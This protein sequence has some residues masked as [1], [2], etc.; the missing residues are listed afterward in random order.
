M[1]QH[2][3]SFARLYE[4]LLLAGVELTPQD[5]QLFLTLARTRIETKKTY[6]EHRSDKEWD[7][8]RLR[9][10]R[11]G[12]G[13]GSREPTNPLASQVFS[14]PQL[15]ETRHLVGR[16]DWLASIMAS[17]QDALPKKLLVMQGPIG[18][19]KSSELHRIALQVISAEP[20]RHHVMLCELPAGEQGGD[21]QRTLDLLLGALLAE[22]APSDSA[23]PLTSLDVR[24]TFVLRCLEKS[25]R[26]FLLLVDNAERVLDERATR[27]RREQFL[28]S[29]AQPASHHAG[30]GNEGM[31]RLVRG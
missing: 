12:P 3:I 21:P 7:E 24:I 15:V 29:P 30:T 28:R 4:A 14:N 16:E 13:G 31:V 27:P 2:L 10:S 23:T 9:L 11:S 22:I 19:G 26:P 25:A 20:S 5:R 1:L 8:L 17:L 6:Q 18:I